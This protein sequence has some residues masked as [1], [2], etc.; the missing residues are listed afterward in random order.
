MKKM[1]YVII[2]IACICLILVG[3]F[4]F[5]KDNVTTD[6]DLTE[7]EKLIVRDLEE[8]YPKTPREVVKFYNRILI[9]YYNGEATTT[10]LGKLVDQVLLLLDEDLLVVNPR[11]EYYSSVLSEIEE[12]KR[13]N[14]RVVSAEVCDSKDVKYVDDVKEGTSEVDKLAYVN[15]SYFINTDGEFAYSYQQYV[16]RQDDD[17]RWK[18]LGFYKIEGE[19]SDNE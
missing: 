1:K 16:L 17:G 7:V 15:T 10:Q 2:G 12:Y 14:K 11:D 13:L 19:P 8:D 6:K 5:S 9:S 3:F 4:F 18:I